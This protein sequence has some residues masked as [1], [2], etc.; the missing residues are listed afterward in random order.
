MNLKYLI[1]HQRLMAKEV[2]IWNSLRQS[3]DGA[4]FF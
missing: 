4:D 2:H 1:G 3:D